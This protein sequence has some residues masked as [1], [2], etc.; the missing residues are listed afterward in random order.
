MDYNRTIMFEA[1]DAVARR[2]LALL[3]IILVTI[4]CY[5]IG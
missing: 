2:R 1:S 5:C 3:A 4:P